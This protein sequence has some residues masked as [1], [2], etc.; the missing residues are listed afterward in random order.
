[1]DMEVKVRTKTYLYNKVKNGNPFADPNGK[2]IVGKYIHLI[3]KNHLSPAKLK[4]K[5]MPLNSNTKPAIQSRII[6][7]LYNTKKMFIL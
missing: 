4:I 7:K 5:K 2:P 3:F 6:S 1:M